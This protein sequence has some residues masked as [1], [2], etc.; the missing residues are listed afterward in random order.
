M[1][2]IQQ[3]KVELIMTSLINPNMS[4]VGGYN[5]FAQMFQTLDVV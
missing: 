3:Q 4:N 5:K 1:E 2:V